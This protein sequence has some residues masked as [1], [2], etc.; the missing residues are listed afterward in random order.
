M[1]LLLIPLFVLVGL[2]VLFGVFVVLGRFRGGRYLA[3]I[4][5]LLLRLPWI[6][7]G[8]RKAQRAALE[9]Q[10]PEL[11]AAMRKL[12]LAN[13]GRDPQR[14]QQALSRLSASERRAYMAAMEDQDALPEPT[15]RAQRRQLQKSRKRR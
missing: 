5:R 3:P 2:L 9:Q 6:G 14:A 15:N 11:A 7:K 1:D 4:M 10:N 12:E 8:L 13:A